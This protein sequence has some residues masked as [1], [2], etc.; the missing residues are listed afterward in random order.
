MRAR[1]RPWIGCWATTAS[2]R[3]PPDVQPNLTPYVVEQALGGMF[4]LLAREEAAIRHDLAA[5]TTELLRTV[6]GS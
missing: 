2:C 6:F 5:R 1:S 4:L 3:S